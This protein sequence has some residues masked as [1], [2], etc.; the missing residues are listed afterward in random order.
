VLPP[1]VVAVLKE[2]RTAQLEARLKAGADWAPGPGLEDLVFTSRTGKPILPRNVNRALE[3]VLRRAGL[4]QLR[5]HDLRHSHATLLL[6]KGVN[7]RVVQERLGHST[8]AMTLGT[9]SH[10]LPDLQ[11]EAAEKLSRALFGR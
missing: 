1:K 2:H 11:R 10:V 3:A 5:F 9:Y 6:K 4:P 7:L 8:V